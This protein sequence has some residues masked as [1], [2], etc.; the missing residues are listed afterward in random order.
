LV[1]AP[2]GSLDRDGDDVRRHAEAA[3]SGLRR[4]LEAGAVAPA[5]VLGKSPSGAAFD[6]AAEVAALGALAA[7]WEPLEAREH[8]AEGGL[9]KLGLGKL[10]GP[11]GEDRIAWLRAI[12]GGRTVTRDLGGTN[13]ERM[14]PLRFAAYCREAFANLPVEVEVVEDRATLERDYPLLS[15]VA[16]ASFAVD[17]HRPCVIRLTY[18]GSGPI[19]RTIMIAGKG[20][21]YDTGGADLKTGGHMAGM[22]RDKGGAA[23]AAGLIHA[24]ASLA[25]PQ[26]KVVVEIGA[27]RN[28][29]GADSYV[30]DEIITGHAGKRVRIGNTDAEG[31][32]VMADCL[33]HLRVRAASEVDPA[34]FSIATLT[35]HAVLAV[36]PYSIALD[37][38]AARARNT[39]ARLIAEGDRWGDPFESSRLRREDWDFIKPRSRADDVLSCNNAPSSATPRGHQFPAAFLAIASGLDAHGHPS[40]DAPLPYTHIDI[41]GSA[42]EGSDWQHGRPT[43]AP[44]LAMVAALVTQE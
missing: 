25:V 2:L 40:S 37:N 5:L 34:I 43:A 23:A 18:Q 21:T 41:A 1:Y 8:D 36:G 16:R 42:V 30:T 27:V 28:S 10:D 14:A 31:R 22:S 6:K 24:V 19:Q 9:Q 29:I 32:L 35:G 4:A 13:P 3:A 39:A 26:V 15:A 20:V 7:A 12:E 11:L 44:V 33:S 38:H 17:R